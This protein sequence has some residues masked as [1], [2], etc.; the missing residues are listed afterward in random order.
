MPIITL[1]VTGCKEIIEY[2]KNWFLVDYKS[3]DDIAVKL[4]LL[5]DNPDLRK[6]MGLESRKKAEK[7]F[8]TRVIVDKYLSLY[9]KLLKKDS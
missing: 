7:E 1:N 9:N 5:I 2:G 3:V 6:K 4:K 8:G